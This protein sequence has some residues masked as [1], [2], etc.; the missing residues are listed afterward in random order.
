MA[1]RRRWRRGAD[2]DGDADQEGHRGRFR[3]DGQERIDFG[4]GAFEHV[5]APEVKRHGR[6]LERQA[7]HDHQA[8]EHQH[9]ERAAAFAAARSWPGIS[10]A[11]SLAAI[12]G[13]WAEPNRPASRLMP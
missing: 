4:R 1:A 3:G 5:G 10:I 13:R 7:D 8:G 6:E 9:H 11:A 2:A 12:V